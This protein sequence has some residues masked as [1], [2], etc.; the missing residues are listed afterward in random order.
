MNLSKV[1]CQSHNMI[2]KCSIFHIEYLVWKSRDIQ[3]SNFENLSFSRWYSRHTW[4]TSSQRVS[5]EFME[6]QTTNLSLFENQT[7]C[8][9]RGNYG[10]FYAKYQISPIWYIWWPNFL[11]ERKYIGNLSIICHAIPVAKFWNNFTI[12]VINHPH[13]IWNTFLNTSSY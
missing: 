6:W 5:P 9:E 10:C 13:I 12:N 2:F 8:T 3:P 11:R 7:F 4:Q 1:K